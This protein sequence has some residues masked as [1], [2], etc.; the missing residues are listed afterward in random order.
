M[1]ACAERL[2]A[3]TLL[4]AIEAMLSAEYCSFLVSKVVAT[5]CHEGLYSLKIRIMATLPAGCRKTEYY[6][7]RELPSTK[8]YP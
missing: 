2:E 6:Q 7:S 5:V 8:R 1:S 4:A 3:G